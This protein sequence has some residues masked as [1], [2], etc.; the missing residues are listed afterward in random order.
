VTLRTYRCVL[1]KLKK[2]AF[3]AKNVFRPV[4]EYT[5]ELDL[6]EGMG[7]TLRAALLHGIRQ[8]DGEH[9]DPAEYRMDVYDSAEEGLACLAGFTVPSDGGLYRPASSLAEYTDGQIISELARRL[10]G[11]E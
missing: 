7:Y 1:L 4:D 9:A 3:S 8:H 10:A 11:D 2:A 6:D 5:C